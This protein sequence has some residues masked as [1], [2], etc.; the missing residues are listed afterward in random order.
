MARDGEK[1]IKRGIYLYIDGKEVKNS[2]NEI[3]R[4]MRAVEREQKLM[5]VGSEEYVRAGQKIRSLNGIL[6][7]H[8]AQLRAVA[9]E[10]KNHYISIGKL[11]DGF[12]RYAAMGASGI[13]AI[14]GLTFTV[15]K[16]VD[17]YA[18]MEE[19]E[20]Q[21]IKYTGLTKEEVKDLNEEFKKMDTRTARDR[22]NE[23]AGDAGRLGITSKDQILE[24]VDA[25]D[26]INV[27]LGEDLGK[28]AVKDIGKL[29]QMFGEDETKGLRGAMLATGSAINEVAQNSSAS[30]R[31]LVD[32]TARVAGAANQANI[33][34]S[35]IIG[36]ASVLDQNMQQVEMAGTAFQGVL[37]KMY[38]KPA[39]FAKMAGIDVKKFTKLLKE[40][41]NEAVLQF[42]SSLSNKGGLDQL[43]P[44]FDK[45]ELDGAR[46]SGVLS[47]LAKNIDQIRI[48]QERANQAYNDGTSILNE[49]NVQN[50]TAKARLE[51][52]KKLFNDYIIDL[53]EKLLPIASN[54]VSTGATGI[55]ILGTLTTFLINNKGAIIATAVAI[56]GYYVATE[57]AAIASRA[58]SLII[59]TLRGVIIL[60][61]GSILLA[62]S[63]FFLLTG[64]IDKATVA[65]RAFSIVTK[66]NPV[67]VLT[68]AVLALCGAFYLLNRKM[69]DNERINRKLVSL[70]DSAKTAAEN[71]KEQV[72][73]LMKIAQ[74][75]SKSQ[76]E[77]LL[78][79]KKLNEISPEYLGCLNLENINTET[80]KQAVDRY[81]RSLFLN[82]KVK[83][84]L[85]EMDKNQST[86]DDLANN[87]GKTSKFYDGFLKMTA[88]AFD[89]V[90]TFFSG[91]GS[92]LAAT[93]YDTVYGRYRDASNSIIAD[94]KKLNEELEKTQEELIKLELE[95]TPPKKTKGNGGGGADETETEREKRINEARNRVMLEYEKKRNELREKYLSGDIKT[96]KEYETEMQKL[97][98]DS[99]NSLMNVEGLKDKEKESF[100]EKYL[101]MQVS[102]RKK[103][104]EIN[105]GISQDSENEFD[106]QIN[107]LRNKQK[108]Q[109]NIVNQAYTTKA[110]TEK[111]K[112][113]ELLKI[114]EY[115]A[116]K[117]NEITKKKLEKEKEQ[118][119]KDLEKRS[120]IIRRRMNDSNKQ[121][122]SLYKLTGGQE[123]LKSI[124]TLREELE[125]E[126][127]ALSNS[128]LPEDAISKLRE[129][130]KEQLDSL[131]EMTEDEA[132]DIAESYRDL[133]ESIGE[134]FAQVFTDGMD[135]LKN[136]LKDML[137]MLLSS[138]EKE[139]M[140]AQVKLLTNALMNGVLSPLEVAKAVG[141]IALI[142]AAFSVAKSAVDGFAEGGFTGDGKWNQPAGI[143]HKKEFVA[144]R[145]AVANP[146]IRPVLNLIDAAQ[147]SGNISSLTREDIMAV[148]GG[149][150]SYIKH[151][152]KMI[153]SDDHKD[154]QMLAL[155]STLVSVNRTLAQVKKRF[156]EPIVAETYA[157]GKKGVNEAQKLVDQMEANASRKR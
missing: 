157:T 119:L 118:E 94:N 48:E 1:I 41:A 34:Q 103:I 61:K 66:L 143:V 23:L 14:T 88:D 153:T 44:M 84:L 57:R 150:T 22:L 24:F 59:S 16:A 108:E 5:T 130:I 110:I 69:D 80:A 31:Y 62:E 32:F 87:P 101:E 20:S 33:S 139:I 70:N 155:L 75:Y 49:F 93:L 40:D 137:K 8:R 141:K 71:E 47:T 45:M 81:T 120:E 146:Q 112:L 142:K 147:R 117:E 36:F 111:E 95:S 85:E 26:K 102:L 149:G 11:A 113:E 68:S 19:A 98:L 89:Q 4:E 92:S 55:R 129:K 123:Q 65:M 144:N 83:K 76:G 104:E 17:A 156:D 50:N 116:G 132:K 125:N 51:K 97:E 30:E 18:E 114:K 90:S 145:F 52:N 72:M 121:E 99:L 140:I 2:I 96:Q 133:G 63:A 124:R 135:G 73:Q 37:M 100:R 126:L 10:A 7:E 151:S 28:D 12:N 136:F 138:V 86:L 134:S 9:V 67:G 13:A 109:E 25:A 74:D 64:R 3:Q 152:P 107:T 56:A 39:M 79:I 60:Y 105:E 43:A 77:R 35:N 21:V 6:S 131:N 78:A 15:R 58:L 38:Q 54:L 154:P 42:L 27:A 91:H 128:N 82:M 148:G 106:E 53:G 115:Y 46:A 122:P 29:A 127:T